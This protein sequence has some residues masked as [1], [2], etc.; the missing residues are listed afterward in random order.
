MDGSIKP[1]I[2]D[3]L[4]HVLKIV[5]GKGEHSVFS[6][7][8]KTGIPGYLR[9]RDFDFCDLTAQGTVLLLVNY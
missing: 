3:K 8:L 6:P 1:N 5:T 9:E 2:G 4:N 7:V